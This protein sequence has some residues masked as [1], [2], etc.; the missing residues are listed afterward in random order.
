MKLETWRRNP[1]EPSF[2]IPQ[3]PFD[4]LNVESVKLGD[5]TQW[6]YTQDHG[7][8]GCSIISSTSDKPIICIGDINRMYSQ[9]TRSGGTACFQH[10]NLW[11]AYN[12]AFSNHDTCSSNGIPIKPLIPHTHHHRKNHSDHQHHDHNE[13][14]SFSK[15]T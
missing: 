15:Q 12:S 6:K 5:G 10:P 4:E 7:K 8:S 13:S 9:Y 1:Q 14:G 11:D 3:Y 2:C